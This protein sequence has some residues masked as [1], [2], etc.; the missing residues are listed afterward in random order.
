MAHYGGPVMAAAPMAGYP[1]ASV[2]GRPQHQVLH[3]APRAAPRMVDKEELFQHF[4]QDKSGRLSR[5]E[6]MQ[7]MEHLRHGGPAGT[8]VF[9]GEKG[10]S[11]PPPAIQALREAGFGG[12]AAAAVMRPLDAQPGAEYN[13]KGERI[14]RLPTIRVPLTVPSVVGGMEFYGDVPR[15]Y[16]TFAP[17]ELTATADPEASLAPSPDVYCKEWYNT[18]IYTPETRSGIKDGGQFLER[19]VQGPDGEWLDVCK[20]KRMAD[21]IQHTR[22]EAIRHKAEQQA[23]LHGGFQMS[24]QD[25]GAPPE[26]KVSAAKHVYT[27]P[28]SGKPLV[29][30]EKKMM[31]K[32]ELY[33]AFDIHESEWRRFVKTIIPPI[34]FDNFRV[35]WPG[36]GLPDRNKMTSQAAYD[37]FDRQNPYIVSDRSYQFVELPSVYADAENYNK[38]RDSYGHSPLD[39]VQDIQTRLEHPIDDYPYRI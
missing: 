17:A 32:E 29:V 4:D 19:F 12:A 9:P 36:A 13:E 5:R 28:Y 22:E 15:K 33:E 23:I 31:P 14:H 8:P 27:D 26:D 25:D 18:H 20:A 11:L 10:H 16:A 1:H 3:Q 2:A 35:S 24:G 39:L 6:F 37:W 34:D 21:H 7:G 38:W 30:W